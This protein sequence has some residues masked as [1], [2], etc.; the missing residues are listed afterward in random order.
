MKGR[1]ATA[2]L[3]VAGSFVAASLLT[4]G[5]AL[6]AISTT[7]VSFQEG[8]D[9]Y[10]GTLDRRINVDG[11]DA[12]GSDVDTDSNSFFLDGRLTAADRADF[13]LR[14][15]GIIGGS[16]V[17]AGA[18]VL[19]ATLDM[20]TT[21]PATSG[22]AQSSGAYNVYRLNTPFDSSTTWA[23]FSGNGAG[24]EGDT[25]LISGSF[26]NIGADEVGSARVEKIV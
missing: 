17:P 21:N 3:T 9:G 22:N 16:G 13:L 7:T 18:T 4:T 2:L 8:V 6:A 26:A 15:D 1:C 14:F 23:G 25:D 12:S 24:T 19:E 10:S 20:R 11:S 5:F